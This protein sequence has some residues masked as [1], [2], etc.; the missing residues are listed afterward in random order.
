MERV[1]SQCGSGE[2]VT[3]A[4]LVD[5]I[6]AAREIEKMVI[7]LDSIYPVQFKLRA[8]QDIFIIMEGGIQLVM[9]TTNPQSSTAS[10]KKSQSTL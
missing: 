7:K 10:W 9:S 1:L 4:I 3:L 6:S 8:A 5:Y 2:L